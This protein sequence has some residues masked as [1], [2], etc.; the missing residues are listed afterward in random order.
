MRKDVAECAAL[1]GPT[2]LAA[3]PFRARRRAGGGC[4]GSRS[5]QP[6]FGCHGTALGPAPDRLAV[7]AAPESVGF[8]GAAV[9]AW[10]AGAGRLGRHGDGGA[11]PARRAVIDQPR[12]VA[13]AGIRAAHRVADGGGSRRVA[14]LQLPVCGA[15]GEEPAGRK[16]PDPGARHFAV[17][18]GPRFFVDHRDR[19]YPAVPG[20]AARRRM[21]R[22]LRDL[23]LASLEYDVQPIP[24]LAHRTGR[25]VRGGADVPPLGVAAVLAIGGA[26]RRAAADLEHDDVGIG[27]VVFC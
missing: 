18:A 23:Y 11:L 2:L 20:A 12:P 6:W 26:A 14:S 27:R 7:A 1:F 17:G 25:S 10:R 16:D 19:A 13:A 15:G 3:P 9:G 4:R 8:G 22:D 5:P 24:V 21:R